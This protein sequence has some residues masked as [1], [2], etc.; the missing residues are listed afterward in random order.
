MRTETEWRELKAKNDWLQ[1]M[2]VVAGSV[3]VERDRLR[4]ERD[5]LEGK[6]IKLET[7]NALLREALLAAEWT[8]WPGHCPWCYKIWDAGTQNPSHAPDCLRQRALGLADS[9]G[10]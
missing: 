1:E 3:L 7:N 8:G 5:W 9:G 10:E 4:E 6:V 2:S